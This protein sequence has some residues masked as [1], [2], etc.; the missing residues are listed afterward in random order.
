[1]VSLKMCVQPFAMP[2]DH[3]D[4]INTCVLEALALGTHVGP[5]GRE[6]A[7]DNLDGTRLSI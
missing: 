1:M 4:A 7:R 3:L 5:I 2:C 6:H